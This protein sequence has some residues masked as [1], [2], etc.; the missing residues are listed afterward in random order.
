[1]TKTVWQNLGIIP[2]GGEGE[3]RGSTNLS[4]CS[5]EHPSTKPGNTRTNDI[6][7]DFFCITRHLLAFLASIVPKKIPKKH[8]L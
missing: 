5:P 1:M 7:G 4:F 3:R 8:K 6:L 2:N